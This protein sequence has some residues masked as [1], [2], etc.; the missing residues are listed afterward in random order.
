[1]Y[2]ISGS[3]WGAISFLLGGFISSII[4]GIIVMERYDV[5]Q[6]IQRKMN[7][8]KYERERV[9]ADLKDKFRTERQSNDRKL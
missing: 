8:L 9:I 3:K 5:K 2:L 6:K 4:S 1:M 7:Y